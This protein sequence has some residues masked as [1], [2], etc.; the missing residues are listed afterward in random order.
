MAANIKTRSSDLSADTH[1]T[2]HYGPFG[3]LTSCPPDANVTPI[4][5]ISL[6]CP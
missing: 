4:A 5:F 3:S 2:G 6:D 1:L